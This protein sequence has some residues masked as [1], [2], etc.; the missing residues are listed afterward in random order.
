MGRRRHIVCR[1]RILTLTVLLFVQVG[2]KGLR[3]RTMRM[4]LLLPL[5]KTVRG[6]MNL[7]SYGWTSTCRRPL[8]VARYVRLIIGV[9]AQG[10]LGRAESQSSRRR[11]TFA[12]VSASLCSRCSRLFASDTDHRQAGIK[13]KSLR[14]VAVLRSHE[15]CINQPIPYISPH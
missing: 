2:Q 4:L 7:S 13:A 5:K 1:W 6:R 14:Y 3:N 8:S 11:Y 9:R 10:C 15:H 12:I